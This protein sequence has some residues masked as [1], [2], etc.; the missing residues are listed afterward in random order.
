[1]AVGL[2]HIFIYYDFICDYFIFNAMNLVLNKLDSAIYS[3][4]TINYNISVVQ[5]TCV[6]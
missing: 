2:L 3:F 1:M 6:H 5:S 4:L